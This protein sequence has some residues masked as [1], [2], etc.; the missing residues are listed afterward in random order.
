MGIRESLNSRP[1]IGYALGG[2]ILVGAA[3]AIFAQARQFGTQGPGKAYFS[4]DDGQSFFTDD[5]LRP[6]PFDSGGKP[7]YRA[8]VFEC[9]GKRVVGYLS[10]YTDA[11]LQ[12][13]EEAKAYKGANRPP[14][15][16][17]LLANAGTAG[18]ELKRPG[19]SKWVSGADGVQASKIR[20]FQ[21]PDGT[22]PEELLP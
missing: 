9:G 12:A 22:S 17:G 19:E 11:T 15:N 2:V 18:T 21:C 20:G 4:V 6:P 1:A 8:H 16:V 7:A 13:M 10:R 5:I 14:P 3:V